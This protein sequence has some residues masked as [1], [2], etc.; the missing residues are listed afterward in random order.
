MPDPNETPDIGP[1][2]ADA[3]P[4]DAAPAEAGTPPSEDPDAPR[5]VAFMGRG[6]V[7]PNVAP[8]AV[9]RPVMTTT[10]AITNVP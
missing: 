10:R 3:V 1:E 2:S 5:G 4:V 8:V 7:R 6:V 9:A